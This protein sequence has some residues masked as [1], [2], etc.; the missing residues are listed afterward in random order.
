MLITR[1][2]NRFSVV[3]FSSIFLFLSLVLGEI[4]DFYELISWWDLMLH[5]SMAFFLTVVLLKVVDNYVKVDCGNTLVVS[6]AVWMMVMGIEATWE[7]L[8]YLCDASF[9]WNMM[10]SG[11]DDTMG[12]I[13]ITLIG[14]RFA[15]IL[16]AIS[17]GYLK[18]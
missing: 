4:F 17:C 9:G 5:G 13:I 15:L 16:N 3:T 12:D 2:V 8:E 10:K 18:T 14:S 11:L 7:I 1:C 6:I